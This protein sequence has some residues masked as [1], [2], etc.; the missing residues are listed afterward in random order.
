MRGSA[1]LYVLATVTM[2]GVL[3]AGLVHFVVSHL[4]YDTHLE[5]DVQ[6]LHVAEAGV[7]FYRWYLAHHLEGLTQSQVEEF[8]NSDPLGV[9]RNGDGYCDDTEV[10]IAHYYGIGTYRI[11]VIPP[12]KYSTMLWIRSQGIVASGNTTRT[13]TVRARLRKESWSEYAVLANA[14]MRL[15]QGTKINGRIHVNGGFLFDGVA[16]HV[17][18]SSLSEYRYPDSDTPRN[19]PQHACWR[20]LGRWWCKAVWTNWHNDYHAVFK[21][22][23]LLRVK[24]TL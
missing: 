24:N 16:S 21:S 7:Y 19:N 20:R 11:C 22:R 13:H 8:W 5:P 2:A 17:V 14:D 12:K 9:D 6:A 1:L 15:S 4:R 23:F 10:H 18:S 3:F